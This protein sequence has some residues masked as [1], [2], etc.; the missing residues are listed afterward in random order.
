MCEHDPAQGPSGIAAAR[1]GG[2]MEVISGGA[3][4]PESPQGDKSRPAPLSAAEEVVCRS[5]FEL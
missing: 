2:N 5:A 1:T 4:G 3:N